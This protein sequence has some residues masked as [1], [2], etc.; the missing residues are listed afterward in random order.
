MG[1]GVGGTGVA[2]GSAGV[3]MLVNPQ[4]KLTAARRMVRMRTG[5]GDLC[6]IEPPGY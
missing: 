5:R 1:V 2:V 4:P 3:K 6:G